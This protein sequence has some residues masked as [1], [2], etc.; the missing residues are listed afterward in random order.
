MRRFPFIPLADG[1]SIKE[2]SPVTNAH[3]LEG[4]F[5]YSALEFADMGWLVT[6]A[7]VLTQTQYDDFCEWYAE[8]TTPVFTEPFGLV[9]ITTP[10]REEF[11]FTDHQA[12]IMPDSLQV[13]VLAPHTYRVDLQLEAVEAVEEW[14]V[15]SVYPT[16]TFLE[17]VDT[18]NFFTSILDSSMITYTETILGGDSYPPEVVEFSASVLEGSMITYSDGSYDE[19]PPESM[20]FSSSVLNGSMVTYTETDLSDTAYPPESTV[21]TGSVLGGSIVTYT[22][23]S[24]THYQPEAVGFGVAILSGSLT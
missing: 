11:M 3:D 2:L 18:V 22:E 23:R 20:S 7:F 4:G 5:S 14:L 10:E 9:L 12:N 1:Y 13:E 16:F 6:C 21:F 17:P 24:Y 19:Y 8:Y 15:S